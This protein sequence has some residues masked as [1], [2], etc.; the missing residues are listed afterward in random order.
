M[1]RGRGRLL[2]CVACSLPRARLASRLIANT[3]RHGNPRTSLS[4]CQRAVRPLPASATM[5]LTGKLLQR[6]GRAGAAAYWSKYLWLCKQSR[7][8]AQNAAVIML[9]SDT[10]PSLQ[11]LVSPCLLQMTSLLSGSGL[12]VE[13]LGEACGHPAPLRLSCGRTSCARHA[14]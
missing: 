13:R 6:R 5:H 8:I 4:S 7:G 10:F 14:Q 11:G 3:R 12:S 1:R 9:G 2:S